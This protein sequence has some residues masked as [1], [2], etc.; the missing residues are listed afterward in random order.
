M[1]FVPF[2]CFNST[3]HSFD[4]ISPDEE[5]GEMVLKST[6]GD[7]CDADRYYQLIIHFQCTPNMKVN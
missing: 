3:L 6:G 5:S 2:H 1:K 4:E 7:R